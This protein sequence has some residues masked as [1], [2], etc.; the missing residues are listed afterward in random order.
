MATG[1]LNISNHTVF[2]DNSKYVSVSRVIEVFSSPGVN[3]CFVVHKFRRDIKGE[4][5]RVEPGHSVNHGLFIILW[6]DQCTETQLLAQCYT[7]MGNKFAYRLL[8]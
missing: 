2:V 7:I 3:A 1:P 6:M 5:H 8:K 4:G